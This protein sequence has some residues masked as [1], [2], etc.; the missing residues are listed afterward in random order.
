MGT[1]AKAL[2]LLDLFSQ[3]RPEIGL[4]E[5][6]RLTKR[7][8]ATVY[9]HLS[10]L[11]KSGLIEKSPI[12]RAYRLGHKIV[13]LANM[14]DQTQPLKVKVQP[15]VDVLSE[16]LLEL[17]HLSVYQHGSL[18]TVYSSNQ[19]SSGLR[20]SFEDSELL[21]MHSTASGHAIMA[22]LNDED[23]AI[24]LD[25]KL[26]KYTPKTPTKMKEILPLLPDIKTRG[27]AEIS[28]FM[29]LGV[30]AVGAPLFDANA[31]VFG[32]IAVAYPLT[33][34][35]K[36]THEKITYAVR[37]AAVDLSDKIGGV[38]PADYP[39]PSGEDR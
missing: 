34:G 19:R 14:R 30:A 9:R 35:G 6:Q 8:K 39:L 23:V 33:R 7:D 38:L 32:S 10:E 25:Q 2:D 27:Y 4:A 15:L 28:E 13:R 22:F 36:E 17:A 37:K 12:S 31:Q 24:I 29:E 1:I 21:P 16:E 3:T 26:E 18:E 11:E 20:V 5:F